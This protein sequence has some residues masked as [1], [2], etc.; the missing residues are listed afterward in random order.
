MT[1]RILSLPTDTALQILAPTVRGRRGSYKKELRD[2]R[3]QGFV[4]VRV[5]GQM[6]DLSEEIELARQKSHDI[7]VVVDR[8]KARPAA[9]LRIAE[10]V[11]TA[12][13]LADGLVKIAVDDGAEWLLSQDNACHDCGVSFPEISPAMFSFNN[14]RGACSGCSGLGTT[15]RFD[16][17]RIVPDG[18]KSL[19]QAP[20]EPWAS[21]ASASYYAVLLKSLAD[22]LG[23]GMEVPWQKLPKKARDTILHGSGPASVAFVVPGRRGRLEPVEMPWGGV[24]DELERRSASGE[25]AASQL[26]GYRRPA[27]CDECGGARLRPE[28]RSVRLGEQT[29][30]ALG[31]LSIEAL[32]RFLEELVLEE[33]ERLIADRILLEIAERLRFLREVGLGYLSLERGSATLSGGEGQRVRLATQIGSSLMGVLYILDEPS[34]GLHARDHERLLS[35]LLRL[36]DMGNSVVVVEHDEATMRRAD[37]IVDM[38]PGAGAH[39]GYVVGQGSPQQLCEVPDS[40]TG[41]Y[42]SGRRRIAVP[43]AR[44]SPGPAELV[45]AGC[46][47]NNLQD[48]TLRI[49]LGLLTVV[50]GVSGS[51]KSTLLGDTLQRALAAELHNAEQRPG[52][53]DSLTGL[54][55][56]DKVIDVSQAPIGRTPRSNPATYTGAFDSI[57]KLFAGT[58]EARVRGYGP[59]RFSFN[60]KGGRCETCRGD[61]L[62]RIEMNFLPDLFI[63]CEVCRAR[64]YNRETLEIRY[65]GKSI[66]EV[67]EMSVEEALVFAENVEAVRRPLQGL[68]DVG[69]GYLKLGQPATTLSGGEAQRVKLARELTR[70]GTG[71]TLYLLDEPTTGL[72][73]ED[74][75]R[76]MGL[77]MRLVELGNTVVVIEHH[78]DLIKCADHVV[79]LGPEGGEAG[80][81][82]VVAGSPEEVARH[83][84]SHTGRALR[85]VLS[86]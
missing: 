51:G 86:A 63:A 37:H 46:R 48:V 25:R 33:A 57:R 60:V 27:R 18:A 64:R 11:E 21:G 34:I 82:I 38:G 70:R 22:H 62:L 10:S 59:G 39:G 1:D 42:L 15:A 26:A 24:I 7:D 47:E 43:A 45:L 50:T 30:D 4:R 61:G 84:K 85:G 40:P 5:D 9:R 31:R 52:E 79:D 13:K 65:K 36:R 53:F 16:L 32:S 73:F 74:V 2:Y 66:A 3:G 28:A 68:L 77:L 44:R 12:L 54:E 56:I 49:P 67:L 83:P 72:H 78:L 6:H 80:G 41:A 20:I 29:I 76:L 14:P 55:H 8:L 58:P 35:S 75:E 19:S 69:L 71:R 17:K 81:R 23:V